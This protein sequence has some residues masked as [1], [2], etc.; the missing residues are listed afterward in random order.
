[1]WP[2]LIGVRKTKELLYTGKYLSGPE[3][4]QYGMVNESM[5]LAELNDYVLSVAQQ[6]AQIP[7]SFLALEKQATNKCFDLM[8][9]REGQEYAATIHSMAHR[10]DAGLYMTSTT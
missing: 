5:P 4:A 9:A 3:A 7:L 1:M 2:W 6:I 10:T 8:G